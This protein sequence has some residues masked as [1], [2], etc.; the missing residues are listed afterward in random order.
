MLGLDHRIAGLSDGT[1]LA[2]VILMAIVLGLRHASDPDHVAAMTTLIAS[3]R[4]RC[5][6]RAAALGLGWGAGHAT[7]LLA[8]GLPIVLYRAYLPEAVEA[9]AETAVGV[10]IVA[11]AAW[12]LVRWRRCALALRA[13]RPPDSPHA[14]PGPH[15]PARAGRTPLQAYAI[16]LVHGMGGSASVGVLLLASIGDRALAAA[17]L[18]VF[19]L[20]SAVS[21]TLVTTSLGAT[22][23]R[24]AVRRWFNTA[25]PALGAASVLFG[26][27]YALG[28]LSLAP[29]SL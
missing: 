27:W 10:L 19:A 21:M 20:F 3:Q 14:R 26:I 1:T 11:L 15:P 22:L 5:A 24:A 6:R 9:G 29:H 13:D 28:A 16:G 2:V 12:L 18:A 25:A 17:A 4:E 8:F 7:S 23:G